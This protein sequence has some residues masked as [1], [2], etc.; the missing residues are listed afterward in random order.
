VNLRADELNELL[1]LPSGVLDALTDSGRVL[2]HVRK[3]ENTIPLAQLESF[4]RETLIRIYQVEASRGA[5]ITTPLAAREETPAPAPVEEEKP[6][7][8]EAPPAA[9]VEAVSAE[10]ARTPEPVVFPMPKA[11]PPE[12]PEHRVA[13]RFVPMRQIDGIFGDERFSILQL[14]TTG[15]RIRHRQPLMPGDEAKISFALMK[16]ARSFVMRARVVWTSIAR[17]GEERFS[18]SGLHVIEHG[19]RLVRAIELLQS[20]HE[21]QP[22]R[23]ERARRET[24]ALLP[25]EG[26]TDEEIALVTAAVHR[27]ASDPVEAARWYSRARFALSDDNVRRE[28]PQRPRD[29][30]EVLGIW[31]YLQRQVDIPKIVGVVSWVKRAVV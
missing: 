18:I 23:R 20:A 9:P 11:E 8:I 21:L 19:E 6:A 30:E 5:M 22:E 29:R 24:D 15:L 26:V 2:C 7:A 28:A 10:A 16:P 31:E 17:Q 3:G 14:S 27:F 25:V 1:N 4:F 12:S 13:T